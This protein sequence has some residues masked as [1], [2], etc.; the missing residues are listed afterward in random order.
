MFVRQAR[1]CAISIHNLPP[2]SRCCL[3]IHP[4]CKQDQILSLFRY[5]EKEKVGRQPSKSTN[6]HPKPVRFL[7][8]GLLLVR[9]AKFAMSYVKYIERSDGSGAC[10]QMQETRQVFT[11]VWC[12]PIFYETH[13]W[14]QFRRQNN[15]RFQTSTRCRRLPPTCMKAIV[16][17]LK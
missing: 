15:Y 4:P 13:R 5:F 1:T 7:T 10:A 2:F 3:C 17:W 6:F 16:Q 14:T 9:P 8:S 11:A 12:L